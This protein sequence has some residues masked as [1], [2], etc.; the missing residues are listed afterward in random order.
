MTARA[1][2]TKA[3]VERALSGA[4]SVGVQVAVLIQ[5]DGSIAIV[6]ADRVHVTVTANDLD[7]RIAKFGAR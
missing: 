5:V 1:R 4:A 2:F 7:D 6:P 3:D